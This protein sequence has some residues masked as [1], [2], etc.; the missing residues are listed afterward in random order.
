VRV[1]HL[2]M[3]AHA[4]AGLGSLYV[5][6]RRVVWLDATANVRTCVYVCVCVCV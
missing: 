2:F 5:T 3:K 6:T 1:S 4:I